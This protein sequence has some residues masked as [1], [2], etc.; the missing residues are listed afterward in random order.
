ML[1]NGSTII[2]D[3]TNI[4]QAGAGASWT[5]LRIDDTLVAEDYGWTAGAGTGETAEF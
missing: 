4:G 3:I 5:R 1:F 2:Y